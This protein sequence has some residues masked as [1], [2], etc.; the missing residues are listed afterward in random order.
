MEQVVRKKRKINLEAVC[1]DS[2]EDVLQ[3]ADDADREVACTEP[4][5]K[6]WPAKKRKP[7]HQKQSNQVATID[8]VTLMHELKRRG[9]LAPNTLLY[10]RGN[11]WT[12]EED[13]Q[14]E[15]AVA[16]NALAFVDGTRSPWNAITQCLWQRT[17][18]ACRKRWYLL[19][20]L[21]SPTLN[22]TS[23]QGAR[24]KEKRSVVENFQLDAL[25]GSNPADE[26]YGLMALEA[27][28]DTGAEGEEEVAEP[29][30]M[31]TTKRLAHF[32][33][34]GMHK[35]THISFSFPEARVRKW[36][37]RLLVEHKVSLHQQRV[38]SIHLNMRTM[39][40]G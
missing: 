16:A 11:H 31:T 34:K 14:L 27:F 20:P 28:T 36:N 22:L 38:T 37:P 26:H 15:D 21:W 6:Q 29:G 24:Q 9:L 25:L 3:L 40:Q 1:T 12:T 39:K 7:P 13:K 17:A 32:Y 4:L 10:T 23:L 33:I 19:H 2:L 8:N 35:N 18:S 30:R 5:P